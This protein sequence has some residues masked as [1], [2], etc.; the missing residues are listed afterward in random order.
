MNV[1]AREWFA[2]IVCVSVYV[3]MYVRMNVCMYVWCACE[4]V[5]ARASVRENT[6]STYPC[7]KRV[8]KWEEMEKDRESKKG[9]K[10]VVTC[11]TRRAKRK[12]IFWMTD[13][14]RFYARLCVN[15]KWR[16]KERNEWKET[17]ER[18]SS[19][20]SVNKKKKQK[21]DNDDGNETM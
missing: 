15:E 19:A 20:K 3:C 21:D 6:W 7:E 17:R 4:C 1:S 11:V 10:S 9:R 8:Q 16:K 14:A 18:K 13:T 12:G 5:Y 2:S